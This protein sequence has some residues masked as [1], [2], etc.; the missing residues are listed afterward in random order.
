LSQIITN[1]A[2]VSSASPTITPAIVQLTPHSKTTRC[3]E[4][5]NIT[6]WRS[7]LDQLFGNGIIFSEPETTACH[8]LRREACQGTQYDVVY[9]DGGMN[10]V[11]VIDLNTLLEIGYEHVSTQFLPFL[12]L[13]FVL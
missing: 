12:A 3:V 5:R 6:A 8:G 9:E 10:E 4:E 1:H 7:S 2:D 13:L 11:H